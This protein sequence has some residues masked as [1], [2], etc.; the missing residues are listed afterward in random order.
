MSQVHAAELTLDVQLRG[1]DYL[2][3]AQ[4]KQTKEDITPQKTMYIAELESVLGQIQ[5]LAHT[6]VCT[7]S[8]CFII[9][10][11]SLKYLPGGDF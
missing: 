3:K 8:H 11:I 9:L 5:S 10:H 1:L 4:K 2:S 7:Y 6:F